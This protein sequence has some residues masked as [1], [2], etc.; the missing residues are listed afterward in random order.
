MT[1]Q[2]SLCYLDN[3]SASF[4]IFQLLCKLVILPD[5]FI[6]RK[7]AAWSEGDSAE[8]FFWHWTNAV[9]CST[10]VSTVKSDFS[11]ANVIEW[12]G[13]LLFQRGLI[14]SVIVVFWCWYQ[15]CAIC[16]LNLV[17]ACVAFQIM[18]FSGEVRPGNWGN[19]R[20]RQSDFN[21][22]TCAGTC[23]RHVRDMCGSRRQFL[24]LGVR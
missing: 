14:I 5:R 8:L 23:G 21:I 18:L 3:S 17:R 4:F 16:W 1:S 12:Y 10:A 15:C 20:P 13:G 6:S 22:F 11:V 24:G 7:Y 19:L 2:S 9:C